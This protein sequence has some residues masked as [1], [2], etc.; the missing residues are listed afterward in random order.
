VGLSNLIPK[1]TD[2]SYNE[3][4]SDFVHLSI[5]LNSSIR[6]PD[7]ATPSP[8]SLYLTPKTFAHFWSWWALFDDTLSLRI[9]QG[10]YYPPR[11]PSPKFGHH[12]ATIK[13]RIS[14][15]DLFVSHVYIDDSR[16]T[17]VEGITPFVGLKAV[18]KHF[19][20]DMHQRLSEIVL[21]GH[22]PESIKLSRHKPFYAAEVS[23]KDLDLRALVATF[24]EQLKKSTPAASLPQQ[25]IYRTWRELPTTDSQSS[26]FDLDD[27]VEIDRSP[28]TKIDFR[29][30]PVAACP[31]FAYFKRSTSTAVD[32]L[33]TSKFGSE[34][35]HTCFLGKNA[36][37]SFSVSLMFT[38]NSREAAV[39]VQTELAD[40][41]ILELKSIQSAIHDLGG[42]SNQAWL[43]YF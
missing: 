6:N 11:H 37:K 25:S 36:S 12:L 20:A 15:P 34:N 30:L 23:L 8:N 42:D 32:C 38:L 40:A 27:F 29:I 7:P 13:Y 17:W 39:Q 2:D 10:S 21:P 9:R 19:E 24:D 3:F 16:E 31:H 26:W 4:R 43:P 41:R 1:S 18:V 28:S 22:H 35:T 5:S 14:V 33:V